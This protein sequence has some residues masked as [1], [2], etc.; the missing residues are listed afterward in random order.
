MSCN[1]TLAITVFPLI[2]HLEWNALSVKHL[3][4][5]G[6]GAHLSPPKGPMILSQV[7]CRL[8]QRQPG[9]QQHLLLWLRKQSRGCLFKVYCRLTWMGLMEAVGFSRTL[10]KNVRTLFCLQ[11]ILNTVPTAV[12]HKVGSTRT[13]SSMFQAR[14]ALILV[15]QELTAATI[16]RILLSGLYSQC[17]WDLDSLL[18]ETFRPDPW[19]NPS[20]SSQGICSRIGPPS[21]AQLGLQWN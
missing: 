16:T 21:Y 5:K 14:Q 1:I 13:P 10:N 11:L 15:L 12:G 2:F 4:R 7:L 8:V 3:I 20:F 19:R 17:P 18:S 9:N 6:S